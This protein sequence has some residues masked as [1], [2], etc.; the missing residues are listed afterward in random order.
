[1]TG[2]RGTIEFPCARGPW[3]VV[4]ALLADLKNL[5]QALQG[6]LKELCKEHQ[7]I[8]DISNGLGD[9]EETHWGECAL[10]GLVKYLKKQASK[11][12]RR[13]FL[14]STFPAIID[15]ALD[16]P[17]VIPPQGIAYS[18]QQK[19]STTVLSR[20]CVASILACG[21]LCLFEERG[22]PWITHQLTN[23][24][25][26]TNIFKNLQ[27][28]S[29]IA[30]L[31]CL[32]NYFE[33]V[34][35]R[36][37]NLTGNVTYVRQVITREEMP[38]M[39][40]WLN[41]DQRLCPLRVYEDGVIEDA[42]C[43]AVE[44]DFANKYIGGGVLGRGRVQEEIR[45]TV[46]PEMIASMLFME[47]MEENEAIIIK[48][49]EQFSAT[50]GYAGSLLYV[51]PHSDPVR[52]DENG[53]L[54]STLCAIDA[55]SYRNNQR[56]Q[57]SDYMCVRDLNKAYVGFS[58]RCLR[59]LT[60]PRETGGQAEL[61]SPS[62]DKASTP[63][64][65]EYL[66]ATDEEGEDHGD[67]YL[68]TVSK[69]AEGLLV[70]ILSSALLEASS[71]MK[72]QGHEY[73]ECQGQ[74]AQQTQQ[75]SNDSISVKFEGA[76][77]KSDDD[78]PQE[79]REN[80]DVDLSDW[81]SR[82]RRRSSNLS[83]I[84]SRRSSTASTRHS[85]E[86][87]S[88]F[89]EF[90]ENFQ[91]RE[92]PVIHKTIKE[93]NFIDI[94]EFAVNLA[95]KLLHEGTFLAA[96]IK[97]PGIQNFHS[98]APDKS[99]MKP[100]ARKKS[101][102][103]TDSDNSGVDSDV[104]DS[105]PTQT[106]QHSIEQPSKRL[107]PSE[108][109]CDISEAAARRFADSFIRTLFPFPE[110]ITRDS[111]KP[112]CDEEVNVGA[113]GST[114]DTS[115]NV[116]VAGRLESSATSELYTVYTSDL[117]KQDILTEQNKRKKNVNLKSKDSARSSRERTREMKMMATDFVHG[118]VIGALQKYSEEIDSDLSIQDIDHDTFDDSDLDDNVTGQDEESVYEC[119][120][121]GNA[122]KISLLEHPSVVEHVV[123][124]YE[125]VVDSSNSV[126]SL[127]E[128]ASVF[129]ARNQEQRL[130]DGH[131]QVAETSIHS[132]DTP[133]TVAD[134]A[135]EVENSDESC[136]IPQVMV[137]DES[138]REQM[139]EELYLNVA[140]RI[141]QDQVANALLGMASL[142]H[143]SQS[144]DNGVKPKTERVPRKG[145]L[146]P[147]T[148]SSDNE[149]EP[150]RNKY[151]GHSS[152][153]SGSCLSLSRD[154]HREPHG[155][156][157]EPRKVT[158]FASSLSRDLL[159]NAF[160]EVQRNMNGGNIFRRSSEPLKISNHAA[161]CL[162]ENSTNGTNGR[163]EKHMSLTDEDVGRFA[164]EL[165]RWGSL[166]EFRAQLRRGSC[167]FRDP[168]LS[169]FAEQL[170]KSDCKIPD[171][172]L[173]ESSN[174]ST[175][176]DSSV[177]FVSNVS[178]FKDAVLAGFEEELLTATC[179]K[180]TV[181]SPKY[182]RFVCNKMIP[183]LVRQKSL[184]KEKDNGIVD[185]VDTAFALNGTRGKSFDSEIS[186]LSWESFQSSAS[187]SSDEFSNFV[188][189]LAERIVQESF[190][191]LFHIQPEPELCQSD[192]ESETDDPCIHDFANNMANDIL[193]QSLVSLTNSY[194]TYRKEKKRLS[195]ANTSTSSDS[196][197]EVESRT[198][199][200]AVSVSSVQRSVSD[201]YTD[202]LDIPF[203]QLEN[204]AEELAAS[205]LQHS[206]NVYQREL[207]SE[208]KRVYGRPL[209]TGNWGCGAFRG[210]CHLKSM[211]QWMAASY[212]G[213]PNIFYYTFQHPDLDQLQ[214]VIDSII[215]RGWKV[216]QLMEAIRC[217][218]V[219]LR[220]MKESDVERPPNL[221]QLLL[222]DDAFL[223]IN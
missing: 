91:K 28:A 158:F 204:Y 64:D 4:H 148:K 179:S 94:N 173:L 36:G 101:E 192:T 189:R 14:Q 47:C 26:F 155:E 11:E 114:G 38:T 88:E 72:G 214:D 128:S 165:N 198:S 201:D 129:D 84:G 186:G 97:K 180:A 118:V 205:V 17:N 41:C 37:K 223:D 68:N 74:D 95:A 75:I 191:T 89:E 81:V 78:V 61:D 122:G 197:S 73:H 176:G 220:D 21:F 87:S 132:C 144:N 160:V 53:D 175:S 221:F 171:F 153:S 174:W 108:T 115:L 34:A 150:P 196:V 7:T 16:H 217:Y 169:R 137:T 40:S 85:S 216:G 32:L 120:S 62:D 54:M 159:T 15:L 156:E 104:C 19:A 8:V 109:K 139:T 181:R 161:K 46:C 10:Y 218:C 93:E 207:D 105:Q 187:Y 70:D 168:T 164:Q 110:Q 182:T 96:H 190:E 31:R 213:V 111:D 44:V 90:Y 178:G 142:S 92:Q 20:R 79:G 48:G 211:L 210:D 45:F 185:Q 22:K 56:E 131:E 202:A 60:P 130:L 134:I 80:L 63:T 203:R 13:L 65:E 39:D 102:E 100:K 206:V 194:A 35:E 135:L 33:Q 6:D 12:E 1:M 59:G 66:T 170:M 119:D 149:L 147:K 76:S 162:I 163:G 30:K 77:V 57:Y 125:K 166:E 69:F 143:E 116:T 145:K 138:R 200:D 103:N 136:R 172:H 51:G 154:N 107:Q 193:L 123:D 42:G 112:S 146:K 140:E 167:G 151:C 113:S 188:D 219:T 49:Y 212:A 43:E 27:M 55:V 98:D 18:K 29:Q 199:T 141:V 127:G 117:L 9:T 209:S 83:D 183:K 50:Q 177:S 195:D 126:F 71:H 99:M 152:N 67:P 2:N 24:I 58:A 5:S 23:V 86:F 215:K 184:V 157:K 208:K 82:F 3:Q 25:N 52:R 133:A 121:E 222:S 106:N 124:S